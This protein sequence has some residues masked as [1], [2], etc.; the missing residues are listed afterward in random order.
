MENEN[1][2]SVLKHFWTRMEVTIG[3]IPPL[4][5]NILDLHGLSATSWL[6]N[7]TEGDIDALEI[8]MPN[9][10]EKLVNRAVIENNKLKP[11]EYFGGFV[12]N[13]EEFTFS[14]AQR[15]C[16][17]AIIAAV[18]KHGIHYFNGTSVGS[19]QVGKKSD[20]VRNKTDNTT[21]HDVLVKRIL[22]YYNKLNQCKGEF[23]DDFMSNLV[24]R[25]TQGSGGKLVAFVT[26]PVCIKEIKIVRYPSHSWPVYNF[27]Q[28]FNKHN[29]NSP[30]SLSEKPNIFPFVTQAEHSNE[31]VFEPFN[32]V[33]NLHSEKFS[34]QCYVKMFFN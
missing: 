13:P 24:I 23:P 2:S 1:R 12:D 27:A 10:G 29:K 9:R 33:E 28:H 16:I 18:N 14:M 21:E 26:C 19:E 30:K 4:V 20:I 25:S 34:L 6:A 8:E 11:E 5:I 22:S 32:A 17:Q 3:L 31:Q 7:V 15:K